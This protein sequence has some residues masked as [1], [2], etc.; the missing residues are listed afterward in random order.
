M[1]INDDSQWQPIPSI[2]TSNGIQNV[3]K[4]LRVPNGRGPLGNIVSFGDR[5]FRVYLLEYNSN[6]WYSSQKFIFVPYPDRDRSGWEQLQKQERELIIYIDTYAY[7]WQLCRRSDK[8]HVGGSVCRT[9]CEDSETCWVWREEWD[10]TPDFSGR[11]GEP[12]LCGWFYFSFPTSE[13][14]PN[15]PKWRW[16]CGGDS[17]PRI[18]AQ[19]LFRGKVCTVPLCEHIPQ[20]ADAAV[21]NRPVCPNPE[22]PPTY[23]KFGEYSYLGGLF[24]GQVPWW[25]G[26]RQ[27]WQQ[28]PDLSGTGRTLLK[29]Y[30]PD[31]FPS[32]VA[33]ACLSLVYTA[34]PKGVADRYSFPVPKAVGVRI[35]SGDPNWTNW[36]EETVSWLLMEQLGLQNAFDNENDGWMGS[37]GWLSDSIRPCG[38]IRRCSDGE[39]D[40]VR[41]N[42]ELEVSDE[43]AWKANEVKRVVIPFRAWFAQGQFVTLLLALH[44]EASPVRNPQTQPIWYYFLGKEHPL[45]TGRTC[46]R[47][48]YVVKQQ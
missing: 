7:Y 40:P 36:Q 32:T 20:S 48:W 43:L 18:G 31:G 8:P 22:Q 35:P 46:P 9:C 4:P 47:L 39:V 3:W 2:I 27:E 24:V 12:H 1:W 15:E 10:G 16:I 25:Y 17:L 42:G 45:T 29:F 11:F 33:A 13:C 6:E 30:N 38:S 34:T 28:S 26:Q 19:E 44:P 5:D 21:D 41:S 37:T 23:A 14:P